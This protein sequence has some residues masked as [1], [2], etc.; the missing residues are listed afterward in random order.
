VSESR[1]DSKEL[2]EILDA[3]ADECLAEFTNLQYLAVK[4][5][6]LIK[7][8][9]SENYLIQNYEILR[10]RQMH[11]AQIIKETSSLFTMSEVERKA[12]FLN[13][14]KTQE[15][16]KNLSQ[17]IDFGMNMIGALANLLKEQIN[18]LETWRHSRYQEEFS[19]DNKLDSGTLE[20]NYEGI[21]R[22]I[23]RS[24]RKE[25]Y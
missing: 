15:L 23:Y 18:N 4:A 1:L 3:G 24:N 13:E 6:W 22:M 20:L 19:N 16:E 25:I 9:Y 8:K 21:T 2:I 7:R 17:R 14:V 11:I 10:C 12:E 5:A